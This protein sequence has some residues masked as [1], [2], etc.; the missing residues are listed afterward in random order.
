[1]L[2]LTSH[3][4]PWGVVVSVLIGIFA[5]YVALELAKRVHGEDRATAAAWWVCGSLAMGTGIW[6][7]HF[8]GMLSFFSLPIALGYTKFLSFLSWVAAILASAVALWVG[9][10]AALS[11][12][13]LLGGALVMGAGICTMHY[14]GMAAL[15]MTPA[16]VWDPYLVVTSVAI[17]VCASAAALLIFFWLR[18]VHPEQTRAHQVAAAIVMGVAISGMHYTGMAAASFPARSLCLSAQSLSG[19]SLGTV[20]VVLP[21]VVLA[22]TLGASMIEAR[23]QLMRSMAGG[24]RRRA[25][26]EEPGRNA[27]VDS[28]TGLPNRVLFEERLTHAVARLDRSGA[29]YGSRRSEKVA[30]LFVDLD[31]FKP[32]NDSFGHAAGD[33]VLLEVSRRLASTVRASDTAARLGGDEF[34]LL[35][36]KVRDF[37][38]CQRFAGRLLETLAQPY[39]I[40][41]QRIAIFRHPSASPSTPTTAKSTRC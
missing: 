23:H 8:V 20:I 27:Y 40:D 37:A 38:D 17:A 35:M 16:M 14:L 25:D 15:D 36:E 13:R 32:I 12:A 6:S 31:G 1:M 9:N 34:V 26:D 30:V 21:V 19:N 11:A 22:F 7:T 24:A 4:N 10:R 28:L 33:T 39:E 18:E 29:P 5:S 2:Y 3:Y 41:G